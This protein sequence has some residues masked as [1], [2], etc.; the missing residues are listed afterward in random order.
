MSYPGTTFLV[1]GLLLAAT[2]VPA[3]TKADE[4]F[5]NGLTRDGRSLR[6]VSRVASDDPVYYWI[7]LENY[8]AGKGSTR[9][10]VK[11][12]PKGETLLDETDS[13]NDDDT[14]PL[15]FCGVDG[16]EKELDE[17]NY[18]F[19]IYLNGEVVGERSIAVDKKSFFGKQSMMK[20]YKY[21]I[22]ILAAIILG[23]YWI[24]KKLYGDKTIDAAFPEKAAKEAKTPVV[25]LQ[26]AAPPKP[27]EPTP[28]DMLAKFKAALAIDANVK[29]MKAEDVLP[30]AKAARKAGD[31]RTAVAAVRGFDKTYP[32]HALI[33]DIYM[34]SATIMSEDLKNFDMAKKVLQHLI[35]KY[36]GHY[37][38][39]EAKRALQALPA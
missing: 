6:R 9:C 27:A 11:G 13:W 29:P 32:G 20:Q 10:V 14:D 24:R 35:A 31:S 19:T 7:Q 2:E 17:G 25:K 3:F 16:D 36:P 12:G 21:G 5:T 15:L 39:N 26:P 1:L 38:A 23:Y 34:L 8:P 37:L 22:G 30:I 18:T 4:G 28:D 33:P